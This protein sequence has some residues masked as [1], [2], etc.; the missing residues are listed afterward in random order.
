M[1]YRI[2]EA[3]ATVMRSSRMIEQASEKVQ[4]LNEDE[5]EKEVELCKSRIEAGERGYTKTI[6]MYKSLFGMPPAFNPGGGEIALRM[7]EKDFFDADLRKILFTPHTGFFAKKTKVADYQRFCRSAQMLVSYY[8]AK[9]PQLEQQLETLRTGT[10]RQIENVKAGLECAKANV[11]GDVS[12]WSRYPLPHN[13]S[14][15]LYVGDLEVPVEENAVNDLRQLGVVESD[16]DS[17]WLQLPFSYNVNKPFSVLI[18]YEGDTREGEVKLGNM[19]RS[20]MYQIIRSMPPYSYEFVYLDPTRGGATLRELLT[21]LGG[22]VDGN[23]HQL[24]E[25]LYPDSV[26]RMLT[27]ASDKDQVREQL[28][29]LDNR[30]AVINSICGGQ[31]VSQFNVPQF[32]EN[33]QVIEDNIG[34]IPQVFVFYENVHGILDQSMTEI[35]QKLADCADSS[36]ISLVATSVRENGQPLTA[37]ELSLLKEDR[38]RDDLDHIEI[39]PDGCS[40]YIDADTMGESADKNLFFIFNPRFDDIRQEGFLKLV[41]ASFKPTLT[42]E[43]SYEKRLDLDSVWGKS[44]GDDEIRIPVGVNYRDKLTYI[45]L[46][47]PDAAHALLAGST[48]CGKSSYLHTIINGVIAHY[49]PTDVQLWLSDYKTAEFRRYMKNT[50]PNVTYVGIARSLEYTMSFIDRIYKEYE[51]RLAVFGTCTSVAEYRKIHGQDSMPR[52]LIV[53]DEFHKMSNHIKEFPDYKTKLAELLREM[54]AMGMTFLLADQA[55]G[56]GL[57]GLS[58]DALLQLT[59]RMAMRTTNEEYNAV[60]NITNAK[61]VIQTQ[62]K[63]EVTLQRLVTQVDSLG[64]PTTRTYYERCKTLFSDTDLR[65]KIALRSIETYGSV[66]DPMFVVE[67]ERAAADWKQISQEEEKLPAQRGLPIYMGVPVTLK[68]FFSFRLMANYGENVVNVVPRE[69]V[70]SSIFI[71]QIENIRRQG[72]YEIYIIADENDSQFCICEEW[73]N[74]QVITDGHIHIVTYIGDICDTVLQLRETMVKRRRMRNYGRIA[75]FWMGLY[76]IA[77]EMGFLPTARPDGKKVAPAPVVESLIDCADSLNAQFEA[78]FGG[79]LSF[80]EPTEE[81]EAEYEEED[82]GYNATVDISE[83]MEEGP[84]RSIHN[85]CYYTSVNIALKTKCAPLSGTKASFTH[86]IALGIGKEESLDYF[87]AGKLSVDAEGKPLDD[88]TAVYYNGRAGTQF[89]PFISKVEAYYNEQQRS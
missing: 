46:G 29:K 16:N 25:K 48:G 78:L 24:H 65:D 19:V 81:I 58:A 83:L 86:K 45:A 39:V 32:D 51:R 10:R 85:F 75:V 88:K 40:L 66:K 68:K 14:N 7:A 41:N 59:C 38:L 80:N 60:F 17:V 12:E 61:D 50:P 54:R 1:D 87:G 21:D 23:A 4:S 79:D 20:F 52:I 62:D 34:V 13:G 18:S 3:Y 77:R 15:E 8:S 53:V 71:T 56:V 11:N 44:N 74:E 55:C 37:E 82:I 57:Q 76:D 6:A 64:K 2:I 30:I 9:L 84:K 36:G 22:V 49:K 89:M 33:G 42:K 63:F 27:L 43:T 28:K 35:L 26:Y 69:E 73:L 72:D 47:N 70:L 5:L 31:P 67:A